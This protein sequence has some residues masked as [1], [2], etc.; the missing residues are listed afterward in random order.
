MVCLPSS[1]SLI[2]CTSD[3]TFHSPTRNWSFASPAA[4]ELGLL[5]AK[6]TVNDLPEDH[7]LRSED[8][9]FKP[10][11]FAYRILTD[12]FYEDFPER[13]ESNFAIWALER[14]TPPFTEQSLFAR[15]SQSDILWPLHAIYLPLDLAPCG[16]GRPV[17]DIYFW[18]LDGSLVVLRCWFHVHTDE[19]CPHS[20]LVIQRVVR[21]K[22]NPQL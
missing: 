10:Q 6:P 11:G 12:E 20:G 8:L 18:R 9:T 14:A 22:R 3:Y 21:P 2:H 4:S 17:F 1:T 7:I 15:P 19:E 16:E 5:V 13:H